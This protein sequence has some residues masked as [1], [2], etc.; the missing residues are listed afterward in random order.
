MNNLQRRTSSPARPH[1]TDTLGAASNIHQPKPISPG[2][3]HSHLPPPARASADAFALRIKSQ[4]L[5]T[6]PPRSRSLE[7]SQRTQPRSSKKPQRVSQQAVQP[8]VPITVKLEPKSLSSRSGKAKASR[9]PPQTHRTQGTAEVVTEILADKTS[10]VVHRAG[11]PP[12]PVKAPS[13]PGRPALR[14]ST[15]HIPL[16]LNGMASSTRSLD[17]G[18][19]TRRPSSHQHKHHSRRRGRGQ[20]LADTIDSLDKTGFGAAYHHGGPYDATLAAV[21][22]NKKY[23]PLEAV[24]DS[25]MEALRATPREYIVDSLRRHIPLQGTGTIPPGMPDMCGN[26]MNYEEGAD[27]MREPDAAGGAYMR[28]DF[29]VSNKILRLSPTSLL[30]TCRCAD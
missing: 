6:G 3:R 14:R 10:S 30:Q 29:V 2:Q 22:R 23:A 18:V 28:Y 19:Q 4:S 7:H 20:P 27:L 25:N 9:K 15:S 26:I 5:D 21:N 1:M 13:S 16:K 8:A 24:K 17:S 12:V 11:S